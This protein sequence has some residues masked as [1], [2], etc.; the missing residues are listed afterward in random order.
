MVTLGVLH[1]VILSL[2]HHVVPSAGS[3]LLTAL[4]STLLRDAER[5]GS[6]SDS[7]RVVRN[8][9]LVC[10]GGLGARLLVAL[11]LTLAIADAYYVRPFAFYLLLSAFP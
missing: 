7:R 2:M 4:P 10:G 5:S 9:V 6:V 1:G 11:G 3:T 8:L